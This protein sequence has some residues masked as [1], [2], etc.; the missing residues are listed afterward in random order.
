MAI[1]QVA[2]L[3]FARTF[4]Q[5]AFQDYLTQDE[6]WVYKIQRLPAE[7]DPMLERVRNLRQRNY[8]F[9]AVSYTHLTL[10]TILLV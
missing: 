8:V 7:N 2:E 9:V 3:R 4:A 1:R 5:D 10:P 6:A